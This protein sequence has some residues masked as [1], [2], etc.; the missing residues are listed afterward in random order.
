MYSSRTST[1]GERG[2]GQD[3]GITQR[4]PASAFLLIDSRDR[5]QSGVSGQ[6][7][8]ELIQNGQNQ[9]L[10][11]FTIQ[12]RQAFLSGYF[13]RIGVTEVR[14]P[15]CIPNINPRNNQYVYTT[16]NPGPFPQPSTFQSTIT[17]PEGFYNP[18]EL[19]QQ[20]SGDNKSLDPAQTFYNGFPDV[21]NVIPQATGAFQVGSTSSFTITASD[22]PRGGLISVMNLESQYSTFTSTINSST[23]TLS[24]PV[25]QNSGFPGQNYVLGQPMPKM[26]YTDYVDV[27]SRT[28]TQY[29]NV[30]DNSTREN[31]TPAVLQRI[32]V[33]DNNATMSFGNGGFYPVGLS[34]VDVSQDTQ[35]PGC[36]PGLISRIYNVPK[37]SSWSP[38][39]FI[40]QID[41]QLR[42]DNGDL[43]YIPNDGNGK[44]QFQNFQMTFHCS[45][46]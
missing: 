31:Q 33:N 32:Y 26:T 35:W 11:D 21:P 15:W 16:W 14:F 24:Y 37:Y 41:I 19:A 4:P 5:I 18:E 10:N 20:L 39:Q 27:C 3:P 6:A 23:V 28:L 1:A 36:R 45:E 29:Q 46:N 22:Q 13:N 17:V 34:N 40:D 38:G 30:K 9:P 8:A 25:P 44:T 43:L 42:D 2:S 12:K 7:E